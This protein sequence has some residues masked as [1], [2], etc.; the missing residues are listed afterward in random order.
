MKIPP[1][2]LPLLCLPALLFTASYA[3]ALTPSSGLVQKYNQGKFEETVEG[4]RAAA[5]A[6]DSRASLDCAI[7]LKDLGNYDEAIFV[8]RRQL[9][10]TGND[11]SMLSLL[12]RL[13]YLDGRNRQALNVISRLLALQPDDIE[14][15]L[16]AGLCY[17]ALGND[18]QARRSLE[19]A[20]ALDKD[21]ITAH[22]TLGQLYLRQNRLRE[23]EE[24][25]KQANLIDASIRKVYGCWGDVLFQLGNY[26]EA[27]RVYEKLRLI[28]PRDASV[29]DRLEQARQKLGQDYFRDQHEKIAESRRQKTVPLVKPVTYYEKATKVRVGL[30]RGFEGVLK[31]KCSTPFE[32]LDTKG[33]VF[34]CA[35][36]SLYE[37]HPGTGR[38]SVTDGS[39]TGHSSAGMRI[40][41]L[42]PEGCVMFFALQ[43]GA[44]T[45]WAGP[46]DR[47][48]R[49]VI[50]ISV[51]EG[52]PG[53]DV[54]NTVTL[55]EYLY[56][57]VPSEMP[58][59][60]PIE[61]LKAQAVAAR[62]EAVR[63]L[64]RHKADGFDFCPEVHCQSY[65]GVEKETEATREAVDETAGVIMTHAGKPVDAIY[66]SCCGGHTQDNIF[67]DGDPIPY[68][69]GRPDTD[70]DIDLSFPLSP[71]GLESWLRYPPKGILCDIP[72][73]QNTS[74]FRW[75]RVY[76]TEEFS[77]LISKTKDIGT[78]RKVLVIRRNK[79]GHAEAVR[80]KGSGGVLVIEK[81]LSIRKTLGDLRSGLFK[82]EVKYGPARAPEQF[83]FYGG[84]W[85]HGVGLCQSGA[86]GLA[87]RG[88]D[89]TE[90]LRHYFNGV[91]FKKLY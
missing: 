85:G 43:T 5:G 36:D 35:P 7:V 82:V 50:D 39:G 34:T 14:A 33:V 47:S 76:S 58:S 1:R 62:A 27:F 52:R 56:S 20:V 65:Y 69:K 48:F 72:S 46:Q 86:C 71:S 22:L 51:K 79:S 59:N 11:P 44:G 37:I 26:R 81:E 16:L 66:S 41:P 70:E 87:A 25:F 89:Y 10:R 49:G 60:W 63:K 23:S 84:G 78:V 54:V 67:G 57:V 2:I 61:A 29:K 42:K 83:I 73:F 90:I 17:E 13:Y 3:S 30:A 4:Y 55:E 32:I 80:I 31:F 40:I 6:G 68:F 8:L 53:Y 9:Q 75:V 88:R 64:G 12:A 21:N 77:Q 91:S 74:S 24:N 38:V 28:D 15:N 18:E 45:F 19:K